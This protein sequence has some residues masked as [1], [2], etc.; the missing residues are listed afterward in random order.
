MNRKIVIDDYEGFL[1][2]IL[3][4]I[5]KFQQMRVHFKPS[6]YNLKMESK[7]DSAI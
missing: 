6:N 7:E 2:C 3:K 1:R 5:T 4:F